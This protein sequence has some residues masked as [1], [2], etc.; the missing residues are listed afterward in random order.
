MPAKIT[1][2]YARRVA[3]PPTPRGRRSPSH[4]CP[5]EE[6]SPLEEVHTPGVTTIAGLAEFL[7]I[8]ASKT[9]KAVFYMAD[10]EFVFV[11]IRGDLEVNDVKLRNALA[12]SELR[13]ATPTEVETRRTLSRARRHPSVSWASGPLSTT[14][15][16]SGRTSSSGLTDVTTTCGTPTTPETSRPMW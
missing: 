12:A 5:K 16:I 4:R 2:C 14:R 7:G 8:P 3:T 13:L 9:F 11:A 10:G 15:S 1:S 6:Q